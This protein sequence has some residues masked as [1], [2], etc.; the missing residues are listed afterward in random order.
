MS[1]PMIP[2][3]LGPMPTPQ[4][5]RT[6]G[7]GNGLGGLLEGFNTFME[8]KQGKKDRT[9]ADAE[10]KRAAAMQKMPMLER[11]AQAN[12]SDQ[13]TIKALQDARKDAGLPPATFD[14]AQN[15][16]LSV[17]SASPP[18]TAPQ[19]SMGDD[20]TG[21]GKT[22]QTSATSEFTGAPQ[23]AGQMQPNA[24]QSLDLAQF[25]A[26]QTL[27]MLPATIQQMFNEG[28]ADQKTAIAKAYHI[29][30]PAEVLN[31]PP[32]IPVGQRIGLAKTLTDQVKAMG[33]GNGTWDDYAQLVNGLQPD[34]LKQLGFNTAGVLL[35]SGG[36]IKSLGA[37]AQ[38]DIE[39]KRKKGLLT[40]A[41]ATSLTQKLP[42]I[43]NGLRADGD[44]K[45]AKARLIG[46][47][48]D[49]T[50]PKFL[51]MVRHHRETESNASRNATTNEGKLKVAMQSAEHGGFKE[52][53]AALQTARALAEDAN[54]MQTALVGLQRVAQGYAAQI[55]PK[56][57]PAE[58]TAE[59]TALSAQHA[60]L[61]ATAKQAMSHL[62][63]P[64][65]FSGDMHKA[66]LPSGVT[67]TTAQKP[68]PK[69]FE[70]AVAQYMA[71][72]PAER[73]IMRDDPRVSAN[74]EL[75]AYL[76]ANP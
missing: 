22:P 27:D 40:D 42:L 63:D 36:A 45:K 38:A 26:K 8:A 16:A 39:E 35:E 59:I 74:A 20:G 14:K 19:V 43:L 54:H 23:S 1:F 67:A 66:G 7:A 29:D 47:Q 33:T 58:L 51:E 46:E 5:D 34:V 21:V 13:A 70:A 15:A 3:G 11:A 60:T 41:Q 48:A 31:L 71:K 18:V 68:A 2:T 61:A 52:R 72:T 55:P 75:K 53:G 65:A 50:D 64:K 69:G 56:E 76:E 30:I 62:T 12:P 4:S 73:K 25:K 28:G 37:K 49:G 44:V 57:A 32:F 9:A 10:K 6:G 17:G 24:P